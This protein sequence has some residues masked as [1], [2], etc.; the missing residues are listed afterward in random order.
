M[1]YE[2]QQK[3]SVIVPVYKVEQYLARCVDSILGQ[4]YQNLEV[5]L[6][7][8]GSPDRCGEICDEYPKKD[9]RVKVIHQANGGSSRARNAGIACATGTYIGFIDGDDWIAPDMYE[10]MMRTMQEYDVRMVCC[11]RYDVFGKRTL[12]GLCPVTTR[13]M[14]AAECFS[15]L[16]V[17]K[18]C[19][20]SPCDKLYHA[21]VFETV[22]FPDGEINED[23][24]IIHQV[25]HS[26]GKIAF[27][28]R[29]LYY[30][31]HRSNSNSTAVFSEKQLIMLDH[32]RNIV[33]FIRENYPSLSDEAEGYYNKLLITIL[34]IINMSPRDVRSRNKKIYREKLAELKGRKAYLFGSDKIKLLMLRTRTYRYFKKLHHALKRSV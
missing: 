18:E 8:D 13:A 33:E 22:R 34:T 11:G 4:T 17:A 15:A 9:D 14:N 5:I 23:T 25:I 28:S 6:V 16:F 12:Y 20:V 7:D 3:I 19:D 32:T 27:L 26:A 1:T 10:S 29:P 30:Y 2:Q 31:C 21:S 24:A